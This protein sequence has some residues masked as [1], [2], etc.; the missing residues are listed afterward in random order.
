[1]RFIPRRTGGVWSAVNVAKIAE[2]TAAG[3]TR[4]AGL[5][6]FEQRSPT[7]WRSIRT[8]GSS[9]PFS[10]SSKPLNS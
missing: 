10:M 2:L 1:V 4:P 9:T 6:A 8:E 3:L 7:V 5:W